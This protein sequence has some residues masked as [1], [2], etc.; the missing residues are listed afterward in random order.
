MKRILIFLF[1]PL[2]L[3][4]CNNPKP[5]AE[6]APS[7]PPTQPE[8]TGLY[9]PDSYL[10][11]ETGG[12]VKCYPLEDDTYSHILPLGEDLL[13]CSRDNTRLTLLTGA[14]LI[15]AVEK[16]VP[17]HLSS[18]QA[19]AEG[20]TYMDTE[21]RTVIF[22][23]SALREINRLKMPEDLIG[24][25]WVSPGW[26]VVYY[27]TSS[28]LRA[29]DLE[30]G[31]SRL[32]T[33]QHTSGQSVTGVFLDGKVIRCEIREPDD[34][35]L[36]RYISSENGEIL[37]EGS[38]LTNLHTAGDR[39]FAVLDQGPVQELLFNQGDSIRNLWLEVTE[40]GI[41]PLPEQNAVLSVAE[42][43]SGYRV[44]Y[45]DLV[46]GKRTASVDLEKIQTILDIRGDASGNGIWLLAQDGN[47]GADV[48][49]HWDI[50]A[51]ETGDSS[52][53]THPHY[54]R[55]EPD[56]AGLQDLQEELAHLGQAYSVEFL[57]GDSA[58]S[59]LPAGC[60]AESEYLEQ[61]YRRY[62]PVILQ[63]MSRFPKDFFQMAAEHS[64]SG[65]IHIGLVRSIC[66]TVPDMPV[67]QC[68]NN[69]EFYLVLPL[70]SMLEQ[71]FYHG[72]SHLADT[73]ILSVCTAYYNWNALNPKGFSYANNYKDNHNRDNAHY[74]EGKNRAFVDFFSTS[75]A[76]EDRARIMEYACMPGN[77]AV[78]RSETMQQKLKTLCDGIRQAFSLETEDP[79]WEQYLVTENN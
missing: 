76:A 56:T 31:I 23:N 44:S 42:F 36:T 20:I 30:T 14:D 12:S 22:L 29:M 77:E 57:I 68:W 32:V 4:G 37:W 78:F 34:T 46:N 24:G 53:Y 8:V 27:C 72:I 33:E 49:C 54:T 43:S 1:L 39:W 25:V 26:D 55:N 7:I 35:I 16:E 64:P 21:N 70:D 50:R 45:Y 9:D 79:I 75:Y 10:E 2:L 69:G 6:S 52:N 15:P 3:A 28:G 58:A 65:Q 51:S 61:A 18:L 40:S 38:N 41:F 17:F 13:L 63:V 67:L 73:R 48:L 11:Q 71:N 60:T 62:I 66:G 74:W 47:H 5:P 19:G 59:I